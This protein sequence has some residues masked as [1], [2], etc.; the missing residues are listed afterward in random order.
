MKLKREKFSYVEVFRRFRYFCT[1]EW[2]RAHKCPSF[3]M[4][5]PTQPLRLYMCIFYP[6]RIYFV[7][8]FENRAK[9]LVIEFHHCQSECVYLSF[10]FF[11]NSF[12]LISGKRTKSPT[13]YSGP[14]NPDIA[15]QHF[16]FQATVKTIFVYWQLNIKWNLKIKK[17]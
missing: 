7:Y 17:E 4:D 9:I 15:L 12:K 8:K 13:P 11:I 14:S 10:K 1:N 5:S 16:Q 2:T 6:F 3:C